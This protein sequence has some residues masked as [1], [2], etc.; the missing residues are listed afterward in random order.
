MSSWATNVDHRAGVRPFGLAGLP[1]EREQRV[2]GHTPM[3]P[4]ETQT[5]V[6]TRSYHSTCFTQ[7][8]QTIPPDA[9]HTGGDSETG[10]RE[11]QRKH[12]PHADVGCRGARGCQHGQ[13][14]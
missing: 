9:M 8:R 7:R 5:D 2:R 1:E 12:V 13:P 11:R 4:P 6:P 10:L 3:I 14:P